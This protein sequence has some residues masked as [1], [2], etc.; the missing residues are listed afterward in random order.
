MVDD[1]VNTG[2]MTI[3][4]LEEFNDCQFLK[5]DLC[6]V[7]NVHYVHMYAYVLYILFVYFNTLSVF[8]S[9]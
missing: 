9:K 1:N 2:F 4:F 6:E 3:G 8:Q 5:K 7:N